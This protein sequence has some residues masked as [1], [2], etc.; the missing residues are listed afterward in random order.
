MTFITDLVPGFYQFLLAALTW[1]SSCTRIRFVGSVRRECLDHVIVLGEKHL[2]LVGE[3]R[4]G[5]PVW[6][7]SL[8]AQF[9]YWSRIVSGLNQEQARTYDGTLPR[10]SPCERLI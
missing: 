4:G 9:L 3:I 1:S 10:S 5:G 7:L 6:T 2:A 8:V